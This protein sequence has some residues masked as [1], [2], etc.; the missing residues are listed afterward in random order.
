VAGDAT[1][2]Q[3]KKVKADATRKEI[4]TARERFVVTVISYW[5]STTSEVLKWVRIV[6]FLQIS[7]ALLML[8]NGGST[9]YVTSL[10]VNN[11]TNHEL[12]MA[13]LAIKSFKLYSSLL[14]SE[15]ACSMTSKDFIAIILNWVQS[16][17]L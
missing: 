8:R 13:T 2:T 1:N 9:R 4:A 6:L 7:F 12:T 15:M 11:N 16:P 17:F 14:T 5:M 10:S 3:A